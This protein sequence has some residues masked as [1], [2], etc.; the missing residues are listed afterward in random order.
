MVNW[1]HQFDR[2]WSRAKH[3]CLAGRRL[4]MFV[5]AFVTRRPALNEL[6]HQLKHLVACVSELEHTLRVNPTIRPLFMPALRDCRAR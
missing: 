2:M 6:H 1:P 5:Q 4:P 3:L